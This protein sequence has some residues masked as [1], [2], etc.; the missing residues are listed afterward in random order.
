M[1]DEVEEQPEDGLVL[2]DTVAAALSRYDYVIRRNLLWEAAAWSFLTLLGGF[3]TIALIDRYLDPADGWRQAMAICGYLGVLALAVLL[4]RRALHKS[5]PAKIALSLESRAEFSVHEE[6]ISTAVELA[7]RKRHEGVSPDMMECVALEAEEILKEFDVETVVDRTGIRRA[8]KWAGGAIGVGL[9]LCLIPSL[10]MPGF[11]ARALTPWLNWARPSRTQIEVPTG[12]RTLAQGE[13]LHI[14]AVLRGERANE[15]FVEAREGR[16]AWL[17][18][19]MIGRAS[20]AA[21]F[22]YTTNPLNAPLHYRVRAGDGVSRQYQINVLPRPEL[23]GLRVTV[24]YPKYTK[25]PPTTIAQA[26]GDLTVLKGSRVELEAESTTAL[27]AGALEFAGERTVS[28]TVNDKRGVATFAVEED[29]SY[30]IRLRSKDG[31]GNPDPP[32]FM[33]RAVPDKPPTVDVVKPSTDEVVDPADLLGLEARAEDDLE[34]VRMTMVLS[35]EEANIKL[36]LPR[37]QDA[38]RVWLL[39]QP[40][41]LAGLFATEGENVRYYI[42][43]EDSAGQVGRSKERRLRLTAVGGGQYRKLLEQFGEAQQNLLR[44]RELLASTDKEARELRQLFRPADMQVKAGEMLMLEQ[45]QKRVTQEIQFAKLNI[46]DALNLAEA[47]ALRRL[48]EGLR[49]ALDRCATVDM[50]TLQEGAGHLRSGQPEEQLRGLYAINALSP[51]V[52]RRVEFC[53]GAL[54]AG[55]RY[56]GGA[57]LAQ[58]SHDQFLSQ[59]RLTPVLLGSAGWSQGR[60]ATP[61][62]L[63]EYFRGTNFEN[64]VRRTVDTRFELVDQDLPQVGRENFSIRWQGQVLAPKDGAYRFRVTIDDGARLK[65]DNQQIIDAWKGQ[66]PTPY[67][68]EITLK[69]GWHDVVIEFFQGGGP[70]MFKLERSGPDLKM[71]AIPPQHLR[72]FGAKLSGAPAENLVAAMSQAA[73][74]KSTEQALIRFHTTIASARTQPRDY[75]ALANLGPEVDPHGQNE[76]RAWDTEVSSQTAALGDLTKITADA[77][78]PLGVWHGQAKMWEERYRAVRD[79]YRNMMEEYLRKMGADAYQMAGR[80]R[81]LG[82]KAERM[83]KAHN[84]LNKAAH[85]NDPEKAEKIAQEAALMRAL[86]EALPKQAEQIAKD[87]REASRDSSR[88][89]QERAAFQALAEKA[90]DLAQDSVEELE[91][92]VAEAKQDEDLIKERKQKNRDKIDTLAQKAERAAEQLAAQTE[93]VERTARLRDAFQEEAKAMADAKQALG[94]KES[95][96]AAAQ[97]AEAARDLADARK[98][99]QDASIEKEK[100]VGGE[101]LNLVNQA[102]NTDPAKRAEELLAKQAAQAQGVKD[103]PAPT[104]DE[105]RNAQG[106]LNRQTDL[107]KKASDALNQRLGELAKQFRPESVAEALKKAAAQEQQAAQAVAE[108]APKTEGAVDQAAENAEDATREA[109]QAAERLGLE[110]AQQRAAAQQANDRATAEDQERL[111]AAVNHAAENAVADAEKALEKA[112]AQQGQPNL[113]DAA[114]KSNEAAQQLQEL[115]NIAKKL[116]DPGK[117]EEGRKELAAVLDRQGEAAKLA[118]AMAQAAKLE[119]IA[120]GL[121]NAQDAQQFD[122]AENKLGEAMNAPNAE[123]PADQQALAQQLGELA[124]NLKEQSQGEQQASAQM[125]QADSLEQQARANLK[126]QAPKIADALK[127]AGQKA[128][129]AAQKAQGQPSAQPLQNAQQAFPKA[130]EGAQ[131]AGQKADSAPLGELAQALNQSAEGVEKPLGEMAQASAQGEASNEAMAAGDQARDAAGQERELAQDL[132]RAAAAEQQANAAAQFAS[133]DRESLEAAVNAAIEAMKQEGSLPQAAAEAMAELQQA[134]QSQPQT[135]QQAGQEGQ[136]AQ[137]MQASAQR[138]GQMAQAMGKLAQ[139]MQAQA[140][141]GQQQGEQMQGEA[142]EAM[143]ELANAE[144]AA[145]MG[146]QAE[147]QAQGQQAAQSLKQ[148]AQ[149]ARS[150]SQSKGQSQSQ[151]QSQQASQSQSQSQQGKG[152]QAQ[153]SGSMTEPPKGLPIDAKTWNKLPDHLRRQLMAASGSRFPAEYEGAIRRYFKNVASMEEKP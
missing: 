107:A 103:T 101:A 32:V 81:D 110:A 87:L 73:S 31:V 143:Q 90:E 151:S 115:A 55:H 53:R 45:A 33:I 69:Q 105:K 51:D 37:P 16:G 144:A 68:G 104:A 114:K 128:G 120:K 50:D 113:S 40:F 112:A 142:A 77:A 93:Q 58:Q 149:A 141:A 100:L 91:K 76:S 111:Q 3:T 124:E 4:L 136:S 14:E 29:T 65:V 20:D 72:T 62:L 41:S 82:D 27:N 125:S 21:W 118:E 7:E 11:Y 60:Q 119:E 152:S 19:Q 147:A 44:A 42:E 46:D 123:A 78:L 129:Q 61:G 84:E 22:D 70:Y 18:V 80:L 52:L 47:G 96:Q 92:A 89:L 57:L 66:S 88:S 138:Y 108:N 17:R 12:D 102:A 56:V 116:N 127:D 99:V 140:Q 132:Q 121:E 38:T 10:M 150:Q 106:E 146:D 5:T 86:A 85:S 26:G 75:K 94:M 139:A 13:R 153:S 1:A 131:Q 97:Q 109:N 2:P 64:L 25:R 67:E 36:P 59:Q 39:A 145:K 43:A 79:R 71:D 63:G 134:A 137:Q 83:V 24:H 135:G 98:E 122:Q 8:M 126:E 34:I 28:M 9:L 23:A 48:L 30:R 95:R 74:R 49:N 130:A 6:L 133:G 117:R 54:T 15:C 148:A 35:G